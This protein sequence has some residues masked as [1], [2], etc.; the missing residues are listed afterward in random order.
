[1]RN[2][3]CD[4]AGM[5]IGR[6]QTSIKR[7]HSKEKRTDKHSFHRLQI[8]S[9]GGRE[10]AG[11]LTVYP[12]SHIS[13]LTHVVPAV[14]DGQVHAEDDERCR[15]QVSAGS[16]PHNDRADATQQADSGP[17]DGELQ[18]RRCE[19]GG[20]GLELCCDGDDG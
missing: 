18:V 14:T 7:K 2:N 16:F 19:Q 6:E 3:A 17:H 12:L 13:T 8:S 1:M 5:V 11:S 9:A 20:A 10:R 15:H 4:D